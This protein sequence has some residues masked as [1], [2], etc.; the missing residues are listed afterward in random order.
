MQRA[1]SVLEEEFPGRIHAHNVDATTP[2]SKESV[3][4]LGFG[5]HGLVIR[6]SAGEAL[7][8]QP[9][10]EVDMTQVRTALQELLKGG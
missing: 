7:W 6:S 5:N 9:D 1:V 4:V 3:K 8:S 10:H 2:E